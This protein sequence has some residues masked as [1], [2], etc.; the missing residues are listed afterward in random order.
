LP[1]GPIVNLSCDLTI[2]IKNHLVY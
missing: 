1:S 2:S